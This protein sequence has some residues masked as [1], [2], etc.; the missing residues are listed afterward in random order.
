MCAPR[1]FIPYF[2]NQASQYFSLEIQ[3]VLLHNWRAEIRRKR[4]G[5]QRQL[6]G[7]RRVVRREIWELRRRSRKWLRQRLKELRTNQPIRWACQQLKKRLTRASGIEEPISSTKHNAI[8]P[9]QRPRKA[10]AWRP[11]ILVIP[12]QSGVIVGANDPI[13]QSAVKIRTYNISL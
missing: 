10:Y 11:G 5:C 13:R 8:R 2:Q 4:G 6:A 3:A 1:S 7:R 9:R 12:A